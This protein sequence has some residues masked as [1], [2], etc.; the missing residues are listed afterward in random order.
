[1]RNNIKIIP[2]IHFINYIGA[3]FDV[4]NVYE[5]AIKIYELAEND[6]VLYDKNLC[7]EAGY[8][9]YE[10]NKGKLAIKYYKLYEKYQL[11]I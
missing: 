10:I 5:K 4:K 3:Y 11:N 9:Y 8:S 1:M 6:D 7:F 2:N